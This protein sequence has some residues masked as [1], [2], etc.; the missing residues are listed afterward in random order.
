MREPP[1]RAGRKW[2]QTFLSGRVRR[3]RHG[4]D[5]TDG[6]ADARHLVTGLTLR[7]TGHTIDMAALLLDAGTDHNVL[8]RADV[9]REEICVS[10]VAI[11]TAILELVVC[12]HQAVLGDDQAITDTTTRLRDLTDS[13]DY[14][15]CTDITAFMADRPVLASS[16]RWSD[17]EATVRERW[18]HHVFARR[19]SSSGLRRTGHRGHRVI[20]A[21]RRGGR[22]GMRG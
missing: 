6:L 22:K 4:A 14:T 10:G 7:Q 16:G 3:R 1:P 13:G 11:A 2:A 8:D 18:R 12:F 21:F 15:Y 5:V 17:D 9:L 19:L 20:R